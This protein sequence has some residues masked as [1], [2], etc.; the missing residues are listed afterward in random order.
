[1][2]AVRDHVHLAVALEGVGHHPAAWRSPATRP[3]RV[4]TA[5]HWLEL[6]REAERGAL[7]FVRVDDALGLGSDGQDRLRGRLDAVTVLARVAPVT[8][9]IGL[10]PAATT[11]HTEPFHVS[12]ALATLDFASRGRAGWW[13]K[14]STTEE[15]TRLFGRKP[16]ASPGELQDESAEFI[17]VVGR[18]WDSWEDGA[19]IR[20][21]PTGRFV[22]RERLHYV[23]FQGTYFDVRGPSITPRPPQGRP[24]VAYSV[25]DE[26][27][28]EIAARDADV[29]FIDVATPGQ[30]R[31]LRAQ[32]HRVAEAAGRDPDTLRVLA[33]VTVVLGRTAAE[34][35]RARRDLDDLDHESAPGA[36]QF[37]GTASGLADLVESWTAAGA[38]DGF[39]VLPALLPDGLTRL[40]DSVVPRLRERGLFR[41]TYR[42]DT[43][44]GH[45]GLAR[46]ESRYARPTATATAP[47]ASDALAPVAPATPVRTP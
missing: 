44:R 18:L 25:T 24:V 28:L 45:L 15:E 17:D 21:V 1:M 6:V 4:F 10:I 36:L 22:D 7:D 30:A 14:P 27:S 47:T 43:L 16:L 31:K 2:P 38:V 39:T 46:P 32:A 37:T 42:S 29:L 26:A 12:T 3:D 41:D 35:G 34:A 33:D 23:D 20:D 5:E 9:R 19:V 8:E 11:T 13:A 40:V